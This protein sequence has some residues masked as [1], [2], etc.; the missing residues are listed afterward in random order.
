MFKKSFVSIISIIVLLTTVGCTNK[1]KET[2]TTNVENKDLEQKW[3]Q[4][5][6]FKSGNYTM[7]GEKGRLGFIY[8]DSEVVRFYP[9]KT[10]KYMWHFWGEDQEF[11][12]KLKVVAIHEND[13]EQITLVEGGLGGDN[14]GADRHAPSNMSLPKSGMW[15]L[16][17]YIGDELFG[18]VYVKVH[19]K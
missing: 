8:D 13:E 6:L 11:N 9:N 12:G 16:D 17:A 7:I 1:N 3:N 10:Q 19:K 14:N 4:S 5:P 15:K 18:S 2:I